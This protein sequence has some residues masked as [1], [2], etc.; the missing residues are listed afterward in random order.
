M[1]QEVITTSVLVS[2]LSVRKRS[3]GE[4]GIRLHTAGR[5][6]ACKPNPSNPLREVRRDF[7]YLRP[8]KTPLTGHVFWRESGIPMMA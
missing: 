5:G 8:K 6:L 7:A 3:G 1:W 2:I 4:G